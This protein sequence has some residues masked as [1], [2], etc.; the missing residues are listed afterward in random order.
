[1]AFSSCDKPINISGTDT[2]G[3]VHI[4]EG[5]SHGVKSEASLHDCITTVSGSNGKDDPCMKYTY[6][7][8]FA[9]ADG[10]W[11]VKSGPWISRPILPLRFTPILRD[12]GSK[13]LNTG[14]CKGSLADRI[15]TCSATVLP[16][17]SVLFSLLIPVSAFMGLKF[18]KSPV[19]IDWMTRTFIFHKSRRLM[20]ARRL[21][22]YRI[23]LGYVWNC[24]TYPLVSRLRSY[25]NNFGR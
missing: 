16:C 5:H 17:N 15:D 12:S 24:Q 23:L 10:S 22:E 25:I 2:A 3:C 9:V 13:A 4:L 21:G 18:I 19:S 11:S 8:V 14:T 1:M 6:G 7:W 20:R